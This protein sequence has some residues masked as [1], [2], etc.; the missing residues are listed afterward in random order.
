MANRSV[1]TTTHYY[2]AEE[3]DAMTAFY[4]GKKCVV[5]RNQ[6]VADWAHM[7]DAALET[8]NTRVRQA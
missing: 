2:P 5:T 3:I 8:S 6:E 7:L 4:Q 1:R